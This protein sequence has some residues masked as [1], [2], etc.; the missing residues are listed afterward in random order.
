VA[1]GETGD[2]YIGGAGLSPGYWRDGEKTCSAFISGPNVTDRM[3]KT[4]D[5]A[6]R[7]ADGLVYFAGRAD[8]QIKSRGYRIEL[9]EIEAALNTLPGLRESAVVAIESA[10][11]GGW[12]IC[13]AYVPSSDDGA[14][15]ESLRRGLARLLP[16]YMLPARWRRY[17]ALPRNPNGKCDR[18]RLRQSFLIAESHAKEPE[19]PS[20]EHVD[21]PDRTPSVV[22]TDLEWS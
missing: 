17:D 12:L 19:E 13:C 15:A 20:P 7:G 3:Y 16:N 11:F 21:R 2:L 4:G 5:L 14:S 18:P 9:G 6:R 10:G 1:P 22:Q 8:T